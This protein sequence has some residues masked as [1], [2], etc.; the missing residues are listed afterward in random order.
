MTPP[1]AQPGDGAAR[2]TGSGVL[3][4]WG[5]GPQAVVA[6]AP[7]AAGAA[8]RIANFNPREHIHSAKALRAMPRGFQL[9]AAAAGLALRA[10]GIAAE[11]EGLAAAGIAPERAGVIVAAVDLNPVTPDLLAL[12]AAGEWSEGFGE[13][14]LH[15]LHPFRRLHLLTNMAAAHI[16]ILF[17]FQGPSLTLT[18][19]D[20]AAAQALMEAAG[21]LAE[22][23]ADVVLCA[24]SDC[25]EQTL[26]PGGGGEAAAAVLLERADA[27]ARRG[28]AGAGLDPA[29]PGGDWARRYPV[30]G[31]L[32][33]AAARAAQAQAGA[34]MAEVGR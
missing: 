26:G 22:G 8:A 21:M 14:A 30:C 12:L 25:P 5:Q 2:V 4:P 34:G 16:S 24:A 28:A 20:G 9:T 10:A 6:G 33:A 19:G 31:A 23:R 32:L 18:S 13:A 1:A 3:L 27:A 7:S 17:G 11:A 29:E 15:G